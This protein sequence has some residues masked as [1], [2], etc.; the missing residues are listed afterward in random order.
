MSHDL[1]LDC[2]GIKE[3]G[4]CLGKTNDR[5]LPMEIMTLIFDYGTLAFQSVIQIKQ[6]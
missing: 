3:Q 2:T 4:P 6:N 5:S 1:S